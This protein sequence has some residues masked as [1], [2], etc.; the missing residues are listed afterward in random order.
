MKFIGVS[1]LNC[2]GKDTLVHYLH[3]EYGIPV[4]SLGDEV[5]KIAAY[6]DIEPTRQNLHEISWRYMFL[7]GGEFFAQKIIQ[8]IEKQ[9]LTSSAV[10]GIRTPAD[11]TSLKR[12]FGNGFILVHVKVDDPYLRFMRS[13]ARGAERDP[14]KLEDFLRAE[15]EEKEL[16]HMQETE[17]FSDIIIDNSGSLEDFHTAIEETIVQPLFIKVHRLKK[18]IV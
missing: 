16:F 5:R 11:V 10:T 3:R 4:L 2:S 9:H 15:K 13:R 7:T 12:H 18:H 17:K 8:K 14:Q 1:G 6:E